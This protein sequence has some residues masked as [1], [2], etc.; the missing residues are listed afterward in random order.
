[1]QPTSLPNE[2]SW[3]TGAGAKAR[4]SQLAGWYALVAVATVI[5]VVW[6]VALPRIGRIPSLGSRLAQQR[7][8][9]IDP[10]ATFYTEIDAMAAIGARVDR[11]RG[12]YPEAFWQFPWAG[13]SGQSQPARRQ[14]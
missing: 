10:A 2:T 14:H 8:M 3:P 4:R 9:G 1:M 13:R 11:L 6:L 5:A 12:R 7:A